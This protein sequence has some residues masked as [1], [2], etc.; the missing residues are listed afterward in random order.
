MR[1][2]GF[3]GR[4]AAG[5]HRHLL[6]PCLLLCRARCWL[7]TV[8]NTPVQED[9]LDLVPPDHDLKWADFWLLHQ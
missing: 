3:T 9:A 5:T 6:A 7:K 4:G 2:L 1:A 8:C